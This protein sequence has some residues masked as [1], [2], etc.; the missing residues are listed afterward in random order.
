MPDYANGKIYTITCNKTA[1]RYVGSTA[2]PL[3]ATRIHYHLT[4]LGAYQ[5]NPTK[6]VCSSWVILDVH[7]Y[8]SR[9]IEDWPCSN[10]LE[11]ELREA[12]WFRIYKKKY[13]DLCVNKNV[14]RHTIDTLR[15]YNRDRAKVD[16]WKNPNKF[17]QR[18]RQ[19]G[20]D[21]PEKIK[22]NGRLCRAKLCMCEYCNEPV[23]YN[24]YGRH[25]KSCLANWGGLTRINII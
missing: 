1:K 13:G 3:L 24:N 25:K 14:P 6:K 15:K 2:E 21:N 8:T 5:R 4:A 16:Y 7:D 19:W 22:E 18:S 12:H 20:R 17:R 9:V 11:L 10:K 23:S